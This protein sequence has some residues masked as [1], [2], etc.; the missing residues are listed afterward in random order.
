MFSVRIVSIGTMKL[1]TMLGSAQE[2][3][4]VIGMQMISVREVNG[5]SGKDNYLI[6]IK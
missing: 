5:N 6:I 2:Q 1:I 3:K 4:I